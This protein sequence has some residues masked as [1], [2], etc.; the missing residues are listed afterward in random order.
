MDERG[1]RPLGFTLNLHK[2]CNP[3]ADLFDKATDFCG[4]SI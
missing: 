2:Y 4:T 1:Y 3:S